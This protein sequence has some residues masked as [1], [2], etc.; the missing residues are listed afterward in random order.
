MSLCGRRW[1]YNTVTQHLITSTLVFNLLTST[2]SVWNILISLLKPT[3]S[4]MICILWT[5]LLLTH[6]WLFWLVPST[7]F[8]P[9]RVFM[10]WLKCSITI[11][12]PLGFFPLNCGHSVTS[13]YFPTL[14]VIN[15]NKSG[16]SNNYCRYQN[17]FGFESCISTY[18][19]FH[20][21]VIPRYFS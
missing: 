5:N 6:K 14:L 10:G 8:A 2:L 4:I 3:Y 7:F 16:L 21:I 13:F 18:L 19:R 17:L 1:L 12:F 9:L 20:R 11:L 15:I